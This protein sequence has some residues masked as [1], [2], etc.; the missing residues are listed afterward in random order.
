MFMLFTDATVPMVKT[1]M[2][3]ELQEDLLFATRKKRMVELK[4]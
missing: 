2:Q 4:L 3:R 1:M